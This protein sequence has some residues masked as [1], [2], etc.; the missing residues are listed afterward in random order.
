MGEARELLERIGGFRRR[1]EQ[2]PDLSVVPDLSALTAGSEPA[3]KVEA[4]SKNQ[5]AIESVLRH[6]SKPNPDNTAE[7]PTHLIARAKRLL[8]EGRALIIELRSLGEQPGLASAAEDDPLLAGYAETVAMTEAALRLV[9]VFPDEPSAQV[10]L[11]DGFAA[12]LEAVRERL[13]LVNHALGV[14]AAEGRDVGFVSRLLEDVRDGKRVS[15]EP[16]DEWGEALWLAESEGPLRFAHVDPKAEVEGEEFSAVTRHVAAHSLTVAR[17]MARLV[18]D[19]RGSDLDPRDVVRSALL[20]D[21]GMLRVPAEVVAHEGAL[22]EAQRRAVEA[23]V[24]VGVEMVKR[25]M[26]DAGPAL[27]ALAG[28]HERLDGTG[29]PARLKADQLDGLARLLAV[30]DT[31]TALAAPRP[32]RAA[33]DPRTALTDTLLLAER[34]SLDR[35]AAE[36]L[37]RLTF[38][39]VGTVVEMADGSVGVVTA[40]PGPRTGANAPARPV[41]SVMTTPEGARLPVPRHVD[42]SATESGGIVRS[43]PA[44]QRR[45]LAGRFHPELS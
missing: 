3:A 15:A 41:V 7:L 31:Y 43:L 8:A 20:H 28:H 9:Q 13:G 10:R 39:P 29:Y 23:H 22:S 27:D 44:D 17:V 34:G 40:T 12:I 11:C 1:L 33:L 38:Y 6:M 37:L 24:R 19:G 4:G 14:R 18:G 26:P 45:R 25:S 30:A 21:V 2:M 42:L 16:I 32:H 35:H 5:E 36:R